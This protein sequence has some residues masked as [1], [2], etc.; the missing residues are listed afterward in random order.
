MRPP[1][2]AG[3]AAVRAQTRPAAV[4]GCADG[5]R[6]NDADGRAVACELTDLAGALTHDIVVEHEARSK[7]DDEWTL[8]RRCVP[9][10]TATYWRSQRSRYV[11]GPRG[12]GT[13]S[14]LIPVS[15]APVSAKPSVKRVGA[16][17]KAAVPR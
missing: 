12:P 9:S 15:G 17:Q 6:R 8:H 13:Q 2:G 5:A 10:P 1:S 11:T 4:A 7:L 16:C 14:T 3:G